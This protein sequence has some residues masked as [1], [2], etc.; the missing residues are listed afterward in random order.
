[1]TRPPRAAGLLFTETDMTEKTIRVTITRDEMTGPKNSGKNLFIAGIAVKERLFTRGI[2]VTGV[3][4]ILMV[5]RGKLTIEHED[6]L[7]GDEW[8][9][10]FVG[11]PVMPEVLKEVYGRGRLRPSLSEPL[12]VIEA[13]LRDQAVKVAAKADEDDEL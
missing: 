8:H 6:G 9:F 11:V 2:P 10:T 13:R 12:A 1:M 5:E 7:D 3:D 4:G